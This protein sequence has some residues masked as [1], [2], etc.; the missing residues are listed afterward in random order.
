[1]SQIC[2]L[3]ATIG[4]ALETKAKRFADGHGTKTCCDYKPERGACQDV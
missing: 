3:D 2:F 4:K 1:M